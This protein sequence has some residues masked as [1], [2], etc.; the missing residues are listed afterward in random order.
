M[1]ELVIED[2]NQLESHTDS[3]NVENIENIVL[4]KNVDELEN[5][6][7]EENYNES[8]ESGESDGSDE[9][10]NTYNDNESTFDDFNFDSEN[11]EDDEDT[12][13]MDSD[14]EESDDDIDYDDAEFNFD[15]VKNSI[16]YIQER[17]NFFKKSVI[18]ECSLYLLYMEKNAIVDVEK[19]IFD[20][21]DNGVVSKDK[22]VELL[23]EK[24]IRGDNKYFIKELW[25]YNFNI[26]CNTMINMF[27]EDEKFDEIENM[28]K[29]LS[30]LSDIRFE[31]SIDVFKDKNSLFVLY[32]LDKPERKSPNKR[33]SLKKK[34]V[35]KTSTRKT[36]KKEKKV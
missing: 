33:K 26:D 21:E 11:D 14:E 34:Y 8:G 22:I 5:N 17:Y 24:R 29:P 13:S 25:K 1:S 10:E 2:S 12:I 20:L 30:K 4:E 19:K 15:D 6:K 35:N 36:H 31:N 27:D 3:M 18:Q 28:M 23:Q 16:E 7:D 32:T 9:S